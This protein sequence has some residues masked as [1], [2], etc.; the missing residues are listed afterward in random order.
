MAAIDN[1]LKQVN[2]DIPASAEDIA[3]LEIGSV[4]YLNGLIYT[5]REGV[6]KRVIEDGVDLPVDLA[7]VSNVNFHCSPA[8]AA[9]SRSRRKSSL[10]KKNCVIARLAPLSILRFRF[11]ISAF[12]DGESGWHSG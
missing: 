6:Y 5:G 8:A 11:S 1:T 4:V 9:R 10:S 3:A 7:G 2:L 12:T